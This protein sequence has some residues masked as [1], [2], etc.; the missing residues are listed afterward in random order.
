MRSDEQIKEPA[1]EPSR[2]FSPE[3]RSERLLVREVADELVIYDLER[4]RAHSLNRAAALIWRHCD[5]RTTVTELAAVLHR[6]LGAAG[7]ETAVWMALRR[8]GKA[9]L[10]QDRVTVPAQAVSCSRRELMRR[11]AVLGGLALVSS[12]LVPEPVQAQSAC[13]PEGATCTSSIRCCS[14]CCR[15]VGGGL[16]CKS[17]VGSCI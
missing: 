13:L 8:L 9:H 2:G 14:G 3:A 10:L 17:G 7:D 11:M 12:I 5:G 1:L 15:L 4:H 6:E 16:E